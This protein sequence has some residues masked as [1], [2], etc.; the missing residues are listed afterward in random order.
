MPAIQHDLVSQMDW[1]LEIAALASG[2][3]IT[4]LR[5]LDII[6]WHLGGQKPD[7]GEGSESVMSAGP[8]R[9]KTRLWKNLWALEP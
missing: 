6:G 4:P 8:L 7:D 9:Q 5:A 2:S 1:W 3:A